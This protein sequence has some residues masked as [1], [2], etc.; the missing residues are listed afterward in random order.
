MTIVRRSGEC[1]AMSSVHTVGA[2]I[3]LFS[4]SHIVCC[5]KYK[6]L[7]LSR[8]FST[9]FHILLPSQPH[10]TPPTSWY[11]PFVCCCISYEEF[12]AVIRR[13]LSDKRL[14]LVRRIFNKLDIN[15]NDAID[16]AFVASSYQPMQHPGYY[17]HLPKPPPSP[18]LSSSNPPTHSNTIMNSMTWQKY[19]LVP[20][21]PNKY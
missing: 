21:R 12:L 1:W 4:L 8:H 2:L 14:A 5:S 7:P 18:L 10:P 16:I 6:L 9:L 3:W 11:P 15:R 13:P 20:W 17:T 19:W